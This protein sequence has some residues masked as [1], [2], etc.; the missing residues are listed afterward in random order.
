MPLPS[1]SRNVGR[2]DF[3]E[4]HPRAMSRNAALSR[5]G[6]SQAE[7]IAPLYKINQSCDRDTHKEQDQ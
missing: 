1:F 4:W 6:V 2:P 5:N 3:L 7:R